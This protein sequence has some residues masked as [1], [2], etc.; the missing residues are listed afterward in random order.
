MIFKKYHFKYKKSR[1]LQVDGDEY[2]CLWHS[3]YVGLQASDVTNKQI[4]LKLPAPPVT[5]REVRKR[6]RDR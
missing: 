6:K 3:L 5:E 2:E 1:C 4:E